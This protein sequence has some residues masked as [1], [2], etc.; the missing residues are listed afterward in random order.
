M[1][2]AAVASTG[3]PSAQA[4]TVPAPPAR[5]SRRRLR[6]RRYLL[7]ALF[8]FP[9]LLIM[10]VFG[11]WPTIGNVFL[12][13]T[14][15]DMV[16][17]SPTFVGLQNYKILFT[18]ADFGK[19]LEVTFIW[20]LVTVAFAV[21]AG[22]ALAYLLNLKI[23]GRRIVS[24][25]AFSPYV[26]PG[27][28]VA[29][30]WLFIFDPHYGLTRYVFSLFG[31]QSPAWVGSSTWA[32]PAL[33]IVAVWKSLGFNALIYLAGMQAL[34]SDVYEAA[35]IDGAGKW[36][37]FRSITWPLLLPT[38]SFIIIISTINSFQAFDM[39][40]IMTAGGP[41]NATTTLSWFIYY[42][43][44]Q[45]GKAGFAAA[46]GLVMFVALLAFTAIQLRTFDRGAH[47]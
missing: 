5:H 10:V 11:Y 25:L 7:F 26:M 32:L 17:P 31:A 38:T 34:P 45:A 9:N 16:A 43:G 3:G 13:L 4:S 44:F 29:V 12:S 24:T 18:S 23:W 19:M 6:R 41:G 33:I 35:T 15:W 22:V 46:G 39:I 27:V 36:R 2:E 40:A 30:I 21:V 28:A 37:M 1:S 47:Q 14:E 42:Q 8:T 20:V